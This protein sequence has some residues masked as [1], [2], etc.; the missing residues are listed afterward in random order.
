[1]GA[2]GAQETQNAEVAEVAQKSQ[3]E[4]RILLPSLLRFLRTS[5]SSAF[6][7]LVLPPRLLSP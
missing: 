2:V 1:M 3:K 5:A 7:L 4:T 6:N